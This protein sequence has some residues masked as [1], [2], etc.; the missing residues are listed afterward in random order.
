MPAASSPRSARSRRPGTSFS[1]HCNLVAEKYGSSS[2]PVLRCNSDSSTRFCFN[3]RQWPAVRRSCQTI[4]LCTG[5]PLA[6]SHNTVVSRW[7]V[8]P[9]QASCRLSIP[10]SR[11]AARQLD[12]VVRQ[13]SSA[14]CSTQPLRGKCC[15]NSCWPRPRNAPVESNTSARLEDV[16][17]SIA[18]IWDFIS[19]ANSQRSTCLRR[20]RR[21][22]GTGSSRERPLHPCSPRPTRKDSGRNGP[23]RT[24]LPSCRKERRPSYA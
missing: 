14:S 12:K 6:R 17:W 11:M 5:S 2:S 9:M 4:A 23:S 15:V 16:P 10:A 13:I 18:R 22:R 24:P 19:V 21:Y 20:R 7:L 8:M 1:S 3:S